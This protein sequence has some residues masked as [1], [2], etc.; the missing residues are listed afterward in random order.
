MARFEALLAPVRDPEPARA[1][2]DQLAQEWQGAADWLDGRNAS[3]TVHV[4]PTGLQVKLLL[5]LQHSGQLGVLISSRKGMSR[6][7]IAEVEAAFPNLGFHD[8]LMRLAKD[9]GGST[10]AGSIKVTLGIVKW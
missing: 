6:G 5:E 3:L 7:A 9:Y 8:S 2:I 10:L 1:C 4:A